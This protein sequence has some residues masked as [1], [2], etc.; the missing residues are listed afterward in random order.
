[1]QSLASTMQSLE[2]RSGP[3]AP[4]ELSYLMY[5]DPG[6]NSELQLKKNDSMIGESDPL[7]SHKFITYAPFSTARSAE[8][9]ERND[10]PSKMVGQSPI[11]LTNQSLHTRSLMSGT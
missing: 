5:L 2:G 9:L 3:K 8:K 11:Y 1:M 6:E 7:W 10:Q 4:G